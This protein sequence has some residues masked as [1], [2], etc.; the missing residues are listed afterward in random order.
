MIKRLKCVHR[1]LNG[2]V[3]EIPSTVF[4]DISVVIRINRYGYI[5]KRIQGVYRECTGSALSIDV[6][7]HEGGR[8]LML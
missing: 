3:R 2:A 5:L 8:E 6:I 4:Y 1:K 7:V